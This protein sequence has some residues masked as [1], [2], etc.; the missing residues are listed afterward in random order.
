MVYVFEDNKPF[1]L[2]D[3]S[4][5]SN[6]FVSCTDELTFDQLAKSLCVVAHLC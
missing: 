1:V 2:L 6:I 5:C 4:G 3:S